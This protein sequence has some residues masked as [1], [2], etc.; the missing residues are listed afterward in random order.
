MIPKLKT[1]L[2]FMYC[3]FFSLIWFLGIK[4]KQNCSSKMVYNNLQFATLPVM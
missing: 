1:I 3:F 2:Q 4:T